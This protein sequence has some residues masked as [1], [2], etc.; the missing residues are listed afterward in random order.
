[1]AG[2]FD[3][4]SSAA[5]S[6]DAQRYGLDVTGQNMANLNTQGYA[7]R[8]V[9]LEAVAAPDANSPGNGV[10]VAQMRA[11]RDLFIE[12]RLRKEYPAQ[13]RE[14]A[15][16]DSLSVVESTLGDAGASLDANLTSFFN[17]FSKLSQEPTSAVARDNVVLQGQLLSTAFTDVSGRLSDSLRSA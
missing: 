14:A 4:L 7:R 1:M 9:D 2:L 16:A 17:A 15:V 13:Q 6:L 12:A 5:R 8:T 10:R 3:S 11:Q